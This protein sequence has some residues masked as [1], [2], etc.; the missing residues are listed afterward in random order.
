MDATRDHGAEPTDNL[1]G[2]VDEALALLARLPELG[3]DL[4]QVTKELETEGV[5]KFV[6]S[7]E[8][9]VATVAGADD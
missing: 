6:D 2:R 5:E 8:G 1:N 9:A 3:V 4:G 7:F